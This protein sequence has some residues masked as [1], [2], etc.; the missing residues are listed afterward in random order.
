MLKRIRRLPSPALVISALALIVAVGG[1]T[2]AIAASDKKAVT[3]KD[4]KKISKQEIKKAAPTLSVDRAKTADSAT[5]AD[6]ADNA[7]HATTADNATNATNATNADSA[8]PTAFASVSAAGVLDP[9]NSKNVGAVTKVASFNCISGVPFTPRG[10]QATVNA[11]GSAS[12]SA[13]FGIGTGAVCPV[14]TQAFVV[15]VSTDAPFY[16]ML[17]R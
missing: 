4:V 8:Q 13:Q 12:Q 7:A 11:V 14:G 1:G 17:Y 2:F 3:K 10:G 5:N 16:V 15:T 9:A 6:N